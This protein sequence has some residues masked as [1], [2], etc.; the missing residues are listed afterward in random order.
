VDCCECSDEPS[1]F[2]ATELVR[3]STIYRA[4]HYIIFSILL[5]LSSQYSILK[6]LCESS[7]CSYVYS[8]D[9]ENQMCIM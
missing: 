3:W 5:L 6:H 9:K 8:S 2:G 4:L 7:N 1:D